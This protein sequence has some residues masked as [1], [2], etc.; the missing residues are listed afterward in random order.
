MVEKGKVYSNLKLYLKLANCWCDGC[1]LLAG[2]LRSNMDRQS[3]HSMAFQHSL[4]A[5]MGS[6]ALASGIR[7]FSFISSYS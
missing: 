4:H 7:V 2:M 1:I 3:S 5:S 6:R